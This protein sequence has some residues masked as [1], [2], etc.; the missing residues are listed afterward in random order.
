MTRNVTTVDDDIAEA[1]ALR[2]AV[3]EAQAD[4]R[5]VPHADMRALLLR[6]AAGEFDAP[7]PVPRPD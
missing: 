3:E 2:A 6:L 5:S 4:R 1:E 7:P